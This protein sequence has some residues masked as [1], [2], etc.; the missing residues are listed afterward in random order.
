[1]FAHTVAGVDPDATVVPREAAGQHGLPSW[2]RSERVRTAWRFVRFGVG[3]GLGV[4]AFVILFGR[5]GELAGAG[6]YLAHLHWPFVVWGCLAEAGSFLAFAMLQRELLASGGVVVRVPSITAL[7][8]AG[9][10]LANSLPGGPAFAAVFAFRQ[11]RR[12]GADDPLAVFALVATNVLAAV[13][14]AALAAVG[15]G[16]ASAKAAS[17]DLGDAIFAS[18][19]LAVAGLALLARMGVLLGLVVRAARAVQRLLRWPGADVVA[20]VRRLS[21]AVREVTPGPSGFVRAGAFALASW[22]LDCGC[23]VAAFAA[24]GA[25]VPWRGLLLAYGAGQLAANLPITPGGLG[26]VEGSLTIALVAFGGAEVSTVAA[27]LV[28]RLVSFWAALPVGWGCWAGVHALERRRSRAT[29]DAEGPAEVAA[30]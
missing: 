17:F 3:L 2:W 11:F 25:G 21:A 24:V 20:S 1:L 4:L 23:L 16:L 12:R 13:A 7:T 30:A 29:A 22:L 26:V 14:L 6:R 5:R 15:F 10:A 18:L 19:V 27:V 8:F 9:N 28:Y